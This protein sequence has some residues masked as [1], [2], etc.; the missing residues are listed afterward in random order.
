MHGGVGAQAGARAVPGGCPQAATYGSAGARLGLDSWLGHG[1]VTVA[2]AVDYLPLGV[3]A[4]FVLGGTFI[5][6]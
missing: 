6:F 2:V 4:S 1:A 3:V 5:L